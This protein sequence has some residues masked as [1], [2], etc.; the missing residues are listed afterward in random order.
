MA[1]C[2]QE[3]FRPQNRRAVGQTL[4]ATGRAQDDPRLL[5]FHNGFCVQSDRSATDARRAGDRELARLTRALQT[6]LKSTTRA[7]NPNTRLTRPPRSSLTS[8]ATAAFWYPAP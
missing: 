4:S 7:L 1:P 5:R 6:S 2:V 3:I 8:R